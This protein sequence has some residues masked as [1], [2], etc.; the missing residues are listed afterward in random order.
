MNPQLP[1]ATRPTAI[2]FLCA[3]LAAAMT[4]DTDGAAETMLHLDVA[5]GEHDR[6]QT[7]IRVPLTVPAGHEQRELVHLVAAD[8]TVLL[9][10]LTP[11]SAIDA[12]QEQL[13]PRRR[14]LH[15][16]VPR[17]KAGHT[18]R[19]TLRLAEVS[20]PGDEEW[21]RWSEQAGQFVELQR[22]SRPVL[23]Y[24]CAPLDDSSP[25][26]REQT[27]KVFHHLYAPDGQT[28]VTKGPGGR[29]TH[30]RGLFYG[31]NRV[32]YDGG[33]KRCDVWHCSG[34]AHQSHAGFVQQVAGP[35]MARHAM[36]VDW[37]GPGKEVFAREL[38]ELTV[39]RVPGG[40]L[41]EFASLLQTRAGA[42]RLDGD[43]QHAGFHFRASNEVADSTSKQTYYLRPDGRGA[44]GAT[45]N[46]DARTRDPKTVNLPWNAMSFVLGGQR[47]TA[48]YL[49]YPRNPKEARYSERDYGRFGSYFEYDLDAEHPLLVRYRVW[50]Q[51]GE[52]E[53]QQVQAL[54]DD[55][56]APP[57]VA[58]K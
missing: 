24:M 42:V 52:M 48:A 5:A 34:D 51:P 15:F 37:H 17:L 32:S 46:W 9:G 23:R 18:L 25:A 43:P 49:D 14:E 13:D 45:R 38:R 4:I 22:G 11:P 41:V 31:F 35:V 3:G 33:N 58:V 12:A 57:Q 47:Y 7:P 40:Q 36:H 10:Q 44:P 53:G 8:G 2:W 26:A 56:V 19:L 54:C 50:L 27:Y 29:Y 28:L 16:I 21:Y 30:H 55:F 39:Y 6:Q 1:R 20:P